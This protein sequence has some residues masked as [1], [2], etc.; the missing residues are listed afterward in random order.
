MANLAR[1]ANIHVRIVKMVEDAI[2]T[3]SVANVRPDGRE[4]F[5]NCL[6]W[7]AHGAPDAE[8]DANAAV[9]FAIRQVANVFAQ[10]ERIVPMIAQL[11]NLDLD[12]IIIFYSF[13]NFLKIF[14]LIFRLLWSKLCLPLPTKLSRWP[15][16]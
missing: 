2:G 6:V 4:Q 12:G 3:K 7:R 1:I 15:M 14:Q 16:R 5:V 8:G 10:M 9:A 11:V 13:K